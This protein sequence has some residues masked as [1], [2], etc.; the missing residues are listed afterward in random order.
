MQYWVHDEKYFWQRSSCRA[1]ESFAL[2]NKSWFT[3][4]RKVLLITAVNCAYFMNSYWSL[5]T[6]SFL[7]SDRKIK[8]RRVL[9]AGVSCPWNQLMQSLPLPLWYCR[10]SARNF[11]ADYC[12]IVYLLLLIFNR[13]SC[14]EHFCCLFVMIW[15]KQS[16][17]IL[18]WP[19]HNEFIKWVESWFCI[20]CDVELVR[21]WG[22]GVVM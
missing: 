4:I 9:I 15:T 8:D 7:L 14:F 17:N 21:T 10:C 22:S 1:C 19:C 18:S 5:L 16:S 11:L 6:R 20:D 2:T 12:D 13:K 3:I